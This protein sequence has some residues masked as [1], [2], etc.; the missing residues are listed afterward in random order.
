MRK[1]VS[2]R[3]EAIRDT[4]RRDTLEID[5]QSNLSAEDPEMGEES[6]TAEIQDRK[7]PGGGPKTLQIRTP[8]GSAR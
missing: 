5:Q 1:E 2:A 6:P 8:T 3:V 4:V 7:Q